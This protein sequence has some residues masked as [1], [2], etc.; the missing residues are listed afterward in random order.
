MILR[1]VS[2]ADVRRGEKPTCGLSIQRNGPNVVLVGGAV[3]LAGLG[4]SL[5]G[6][7]GQA[8]VYDKTGNTDRFNV[9]LEFALDENVRP[10]ILPQQETDS[11]N[12]ARGQTIFTAVEDQLGLKLE[13]SRAPR[14]YIAIDRV[15]RPSPN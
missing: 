5:G 12:V 1:P 8:R 3:Q 11:S 6:N 9:V 7:L 14:D 15:E 4:R 13:P 10:L 2:F